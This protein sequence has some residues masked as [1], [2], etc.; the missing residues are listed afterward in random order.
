MGTADCT[1]NVDERKAFCLYLPSVKICVSSVAQL[2]CFG[3]PLTYSLS[4]SELPAMKRFSKWLAQVAIALLLPGL[5][6]A[7]TTRE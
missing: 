4:L 3:T 1:E 6:L 5:A 7:H 2:F